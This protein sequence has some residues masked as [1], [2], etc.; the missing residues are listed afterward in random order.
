MVS[1]FEKDNFAINPWEADPENYKNNWKPK[2]VQKCQY[3]RNC[4]VIAT[5][6][7]RHIHKADSI[8]AVFPHQFMCMCSW[9]SLIC[10]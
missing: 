5:W 6:C 9:Y 7:W 3:L 8:V 4:E 2:K 10:H 1:D